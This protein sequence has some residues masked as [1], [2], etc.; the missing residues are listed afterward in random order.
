MA[1]YVYQ[2]IPNLPTQTSPPVGRR[3]ATIASL[4]NEYSGLNAGGACALALAINRI[5]DEVYG[6]MVQNLTTL[7]GS[8][9]SASRIRTQELALMGSQYLRDY[10]AGSDDAAGLYHYNFFHVWF[11][12]QAV[13]LL[14]EPDPIWGGGGDYNGTRVDFTSTV[15]P[16]PINGDMEYMPEVI[17]LSG[18]IGSCLESTTIEAFKNEDSVSTSTLLQRAN[19]AGMPVYYIDASNVDT[20]LP[21]LTLE[22]SVKNKIQNHISAYQGRPDYEPFAVAHRDPIRVNRWLGA[23]YLIGNA[24]DGTGMYLINGGW[25]E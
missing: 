15:S 8:G 3:T 4:E 21:S 24:L 1:L 22:S 17:E 20:I 10:I 11:V 7:K 16:H 25:T 5:P 19:A 14:T 9:A 23:G 6:K 2:L 18:W 12:I 13:D